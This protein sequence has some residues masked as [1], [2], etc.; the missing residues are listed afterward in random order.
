MEVNSDEQSP[1]SKMDLHL[2]NNQLQNVNTF[3]DRNQCRRCQLSYISKQHCW[4]KYL[5]SGKFWL[6]KCVQNGLPTNLYSTWFKIVEMVED[7]CLERNI[8]KH[9]IKL[10]HRRVFEPAILI[11]AEAQDLGSNHLLLSWQISIKT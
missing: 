11:I 2:V 10:Q 9:L 4:K 3:H 7:S 8:I 5:W 6:A 1:K